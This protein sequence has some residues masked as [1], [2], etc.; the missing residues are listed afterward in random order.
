VLGWPSL[1]VC[2][3]FTNITANISG[4]GVLRLGAVHLI[5]SVLLLYAIWQH[6]DNVIT[7]TA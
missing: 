6:N 7:Y 1:L 4:D 3:V 5:A 2:W